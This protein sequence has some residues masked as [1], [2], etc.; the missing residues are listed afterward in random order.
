[1]GAAKLDAH[2]K[3]LN[4]A[5][6]ERAIAG[7]IDALVYAPHF[8][9]WPDIV[10]RAEHFSSEDLLVVPGRELFTGPWNE[11]RHLLAL[12]L[13]E[14]IPDFISLE[15]TLAEL[16]EQG[17]TVVVPH[18]TY[19]SMSMSTADIHRYRAHLDAIEVY[20]PRCLPWHHARARELASRLD[21]PIVASSYAHLRSSVGT[22][23]VE[24]TE[25]PVS[26]ADVISSINGGLVDGVGTIGSFGR[27]V[28]AGKELGHMCWENTGKKLAMALSSQQVATHPSAA[29]Y[30]GRFDP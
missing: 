15:R 26:P 13:T 12:G 10:D 22:G 27:R 11:R 2:V 25:R 7:G 8:T 28:T 20:N 14:P 9:P 5:V 1:M 30:A 6:C 24:L 29:I 23:W 3:L 4:T 16:D 21:L 18:P 17:A 19:L